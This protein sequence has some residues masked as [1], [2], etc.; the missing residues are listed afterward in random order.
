L[1][2]LLG[3]LLLYVVVWEFL[4]PPPTWNHCVPPSA[5]ELAKLS[6]RRHDFLLIAIPLIM[7]YGIIL[8]SRAWTWASERR[9]WQG[10]KHR[11]G[12]LAGVA[13]AP[14][15][16]L[17]ILLLG[18]AFIAEEVGGAIF[19]GF[20]LAAGGAAVS[21]ALAIWVVLAAIRS[22][23]SSRW[24]D[25]FDSLSVG[26]AWSI[27]LFGMPFFLVVIAAAGKDATLSC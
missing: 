10:H 18:D 13:T 24:E 5:V 19:W 11:P 4:D 2:L 20:V 12:R 6:A 27:L 16:L 22:Q 9:A 23:K 21:A 3:G 7:V 15:G 17:W 14:L 25:A 1:A 8:A 26:L